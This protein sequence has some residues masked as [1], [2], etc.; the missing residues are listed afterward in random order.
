MPSNTATTCSASEAT[1]L[2]SICN[3][4]LVITPSSLHSP[5][6][7]GFVSREIMP[8]FFFSFTLSSAE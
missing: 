2:G 6:P 7:T 1:P 4:R 3:V 5:S 8:T